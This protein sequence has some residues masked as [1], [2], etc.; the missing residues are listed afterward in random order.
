MY[1]YNEIQTKA[2]IILVSLRVQALLNL[3]WYTHTHTYVHTIISM[4]KEHKYMHVHAS[5]FVLYSSYY[6]KLAVTRTFTVVEYVFIHGTPPEH[7]KNNRHVLSSSPSIILQH[8]M[9]S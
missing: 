5:T 1:R 6:F 3:E 2:V 7:Q 9:L 8:S 4:H